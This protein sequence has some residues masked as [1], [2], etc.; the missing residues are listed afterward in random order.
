MGRW[1]YHFRET[2][3]RHDVARVNKSV[4]VPSRFLDC[5]AHLIITVEVEDICDEV[6]CV[7]VVLDLGIESSQVESVGEVVL[8]DFAEVLISPRRYKLHYEKQG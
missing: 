5:L 3:S 6:K 8:V 1:I 7:L 2:S 4:K